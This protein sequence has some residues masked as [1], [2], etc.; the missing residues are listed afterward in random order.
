MM[1]AALPC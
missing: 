1:N